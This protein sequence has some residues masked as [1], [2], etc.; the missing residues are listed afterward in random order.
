MCKKPNKNAV[1]TLAI[2]VFRCNMAVEAAF[3]RT[4]NQGG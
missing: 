1:K 3:P 2:A 4:H